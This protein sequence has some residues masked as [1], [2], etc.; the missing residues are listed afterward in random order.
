MPV[1]YFGLG[2]NRPIARPCHVTLP[3][4]KKNWSWYKVDVRNV[5][6]VMKLV[7]M[8]ILRP[9]MFTCR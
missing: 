9:L 1:D 6:R 4:I 3:I 7:R 8:S 5:K 2:D